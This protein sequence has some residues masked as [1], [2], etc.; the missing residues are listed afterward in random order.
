MMVQ[1]DHFSQPSRWCPR[2]VLIMKDEF[3]S[4]ARAL[5]DDGSRADLR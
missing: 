4:P 5:L 1:M 2:G 3:G